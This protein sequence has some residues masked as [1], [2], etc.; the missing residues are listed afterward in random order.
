M[1]TITTKKHTYFY[2][3]KIYLNPDQTLHIPVSE[4]SDK[5]IEDT[6]EGYD[7][8]S[9]IVSEGDIALMRATLYRRNNTSASNPGGTDDG[10][11][12]VYDGEVAD[13]VAIFNSN[14]NK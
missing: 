4:M 6:I 12:G 9:L 10:D 5:E 14:L 2:S 1:A 8:K 7:R 3:G 11:S 13:Y